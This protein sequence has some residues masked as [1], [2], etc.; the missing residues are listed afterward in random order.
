MITKNTV[1]GA[2]ILIT[3]LPLVALATC[4][5]SKS[6]SVLLLEG[7]VTSV[8]VAFLA[9]FFVA[10]FVVP[11]VRSPLA[12][13]AALGVVVAALGVVVAAL[14]VVV[15]VEQLLKAKISWKKLAGNT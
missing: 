6:A 10:S 13:V 1:T 4:G 2:T 12:V 3:M 8:A 5:L 9:V 11:A 14:G 7:D 15:A